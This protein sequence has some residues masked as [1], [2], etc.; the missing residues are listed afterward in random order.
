VREVG[1]VSDRLTVA[2]PAELVDAV[3]ERVLELL[4][5]RGGLGRPDDPLMT[6]EE[7]AEYLRCSRQRVYDLLARQGNEPAR[8]EGVHDGRRRLIRRSEL[9]RYLEGAGPE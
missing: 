5:E 7:S 8:L 9:D 3:A 4:E 2:L 6:V 1:S